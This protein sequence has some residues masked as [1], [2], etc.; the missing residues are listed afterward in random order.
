MRQ[1]R[2]SNK[3]DTS[4]FLIFEQKN[5]YIYDYQAL[6]RC[7]ICIILSGVTKITR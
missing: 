5:I 7:L 1:Y 4:S 6:N 3:L 2:M